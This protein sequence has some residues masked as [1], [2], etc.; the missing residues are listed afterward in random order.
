MGSFYKS[1]FVLMIIT[2]VAIQFVEVERTNPPVSGE[3]EVPP[4]VMKILR[5]SCYDCHSNT[6]TWPWYIEV[7]PVSWLIA[8]HVAS[9]RRHLNFSE[10]NRYNDT[11]K[12]KKLKAILEEITADEMPLRSYTF[13]HPGSELDLTRKEVIKKWITGKGIGED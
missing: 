10:W 5:M 7:A 6:T 1:I 8:N 4:E 9:G 12:E 11:K 3:I 2:L 13:V